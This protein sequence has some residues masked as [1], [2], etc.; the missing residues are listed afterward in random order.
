MAVMMKPFKCPGTCIYCPLEVGMP[1]SYLSDEPAAQRAKSLEFDPYEQVKMRLTQLSINGHAIDKIELIVVGG[2]FSAYEDDYKR[3]FIKR[4]Y[5][6][7]N[8]ITSDSV[9]QALKMNET[10]KSRVVGLSVETRPDWITEK[11]VVLIRE[12][13]VTKIQLGVQSLDEE[14]NKVTKRG[15]GVSDVVKATTMLRNAG[16]K[17]CYHMMPGLPGSNPTKDVESMRSVFANQGLRPD[18]LKIYPCMVVP[19]TQLKAM[20]ERGEYEPYS[21][22]TLKSVLKEVSLLVPEYCRV[23]RLVR[24]ITKKWVVAGSI[25]SNMRQIVEAELIKEGNPCRCLRCR[26][27]R[28]GSVV[29]EPKYV[30]QMYSTEAG[31]E[32]F[33]TLES[34]DKVCAILRLRLP[35]GANGQL[36]EELAGAA[37]IREVHTFGQVEEIGKSG[38]KSQHRGWGKRLILRSEELAREKGFKRLA[39]IAAVGTKEYYR[40]LGFLD[41]GLYLTKDLS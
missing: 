10:A 41:Q 4:C 20:F 17:I 33:M 37:I 40:K 11:E 27:I 28:G 36:F 14:V 5:D 24:D 1:K 32:I 34:V 15:H 6:A 21:D 7:C 2:T 22:E 38:E 3:E 19:H 30:E 26:E 12:L 8:G 18:Y 29:E 13:G 39:V 16:L 25:V 9:A 35:E 23:D 31:E